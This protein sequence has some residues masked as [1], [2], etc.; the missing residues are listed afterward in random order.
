MNA[1]L[2]LIILG[3]V[4]LLARMSKQHRC[5]CGIPDCEI[6]FP[7]KRSTQP[8]ENTMLEKIGHIFACIGSVLAMIVMGLGAVIITSPVWLSFLA[9]VAMGVFCFVALAAPFVMALM[10]IIHG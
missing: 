1:E 7:P 6:C 10:A 8:K 3:S 2:G 9:I 5:D 4:A